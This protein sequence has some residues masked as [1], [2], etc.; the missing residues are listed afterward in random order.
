MSSNDTPTENQMRQ[1]AF[2]ETGHAVMRRRYG[3]FIDEVVIIPAQDAVSHCR[4]TAFHPEDPAEEV[5]CSLAGTVAQAIFVD[6]KWRL[7]LMTPLF[8]YTDKRKQNG[9]T[10]DASDDWREANKAA[11]QLPGVKEK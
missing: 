1:L 6:V 3:C 7:S 9:F 4:M 5:Q 10:C 2:H 11:Q 8:R